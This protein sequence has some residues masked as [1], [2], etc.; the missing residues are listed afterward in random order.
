MTREFIVHTIIEIILKLKLGHKFLRHPDYRGCSVV[1]VIRIWFASM[2]FFKVTPFGEQAFGV[3]LLVCKTKVLYY[4]ALPF[5]SLTTNET[6]NYSYSLFHFL[7]R[8]L[9]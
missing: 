1:Y 6:A 3:T 5:Y 2:A 8:R 9:E 4:K 7:G